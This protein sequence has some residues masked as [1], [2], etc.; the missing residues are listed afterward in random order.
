MAFE[1]QR[2]RGT[3]P[4]RAA[5][6]RADIDVDVGGQ[7]MAQAIAGLGES[8]AKLGVKFDAMEGKTQ[9]DL[10]ERD[11]RLSMV[12]L[13]NDLRIE[14]DVSKWDTLIK[15]HEKT[16]TDLTP[17]N[18]RGARQYN[19]SIT[20]LV[21]EWAEILS[22][23]K[24][25]KLEDN[26]EA[27]SIQKV[28]N[29]LNSATID[30]MELVIRKV[31]T[32]L[33]VRD[34]LSPSISRTDTATAKARVEHDVQLSIAKK[35]ALRVPQATLDSIVGDKLPGFDKLTPDDIL[36]IRNMANSAMVQA[37][38][39]AKKK[40]DEISTG[41]LRLLANRMNPEQEQLTF[42]TIL[43]SELSYDAKV[44]WF[45]KLRVFDGFSESKLKEAFQDQG[46]VLADIYNQ[47]EANTIT[48][49]EIRDTVGKGLSPNTAESIIKNREIWQQHEYK[50]TDQMFKRLFG[51]SP[52]LG[53]TDDLAA[54]FY[55]KVLRDWRNQVEEKELKG[56]EIIELG[57]AIARPYF[58][59]HIKKV[60]PLEEDIPR[61]IE[62]ALGEPEEVEKA[63]KIEEKEIEES[64]KPPVIKPKE[65]PKQA[66][67]RKARIRKLVVP[68]N[69]KYKTRLQ[70]SL[71]DNVSDSFFEMWSGL[72]DDKK[73][74]ALRALEN[75]YTEQEVL[76]A[77]K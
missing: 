46:P 7:I 15:G 61:I 45:T 77:L 1:I 34:K 2:A 53:F 64:E 6:V 73:L 36:R 31:K 40:D 39:G 59:E 72:P 76:G 21:P 23:L 20:K 33:E 70:P 52:E 60:M 50:E 29:L 32:E 35:A 44:E 67:A 68:L 13:I 43:N 62:L 28:N 54:A 66:A 30:N 16:V 74:K 10:A 18:K 71:L 22:N 25:I 5:A 24:A 63:E 27:A 49:K 48:D 65:K 38:I 69:L 12:D 8:I 75:G 41:F 47:V 14:D 19:T 4:S 37:E 3:L 55:E 51:W 42:D 11:A 26:M 17:K 57:R 56:E 9:A 58:I